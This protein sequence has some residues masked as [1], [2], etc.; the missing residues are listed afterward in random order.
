MKWESRYQKLPVRWLVGKNLH[1]TLVPP[2][3]EQDFK[4]ISSKL[5][6]VTAKPFEIKFDNI[7]FGPNQSEPR[8]IWA[9][10]EAG[11]EIRELKKLIETALSGGVSKKCG[12]TLLQHITLARFK[13]EDFGRFP[14]KRL[15][16]KIGWRQTVTSFVLYESHLSSS[17]ADYEVLEEFPLK[18]STKYEK[19]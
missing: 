10:G 4:A 17:G 12:R 5:K 15:D 14:I 11:E 2:W 7:S 16:E 13:P 1:V 8:V 3:Y 18:S 19:N 9:M 6:V